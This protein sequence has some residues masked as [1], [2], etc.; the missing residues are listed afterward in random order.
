MVHQ[1]VTGS[2]VE[3][4]GSHPSVLS[5][6]TE[7]HSRSHCFSHKATGEFIPHSKTNFAERHKGEVALL[8]EVSKSI[9]QLLSKK[10]KAFK[11]EFSCY[12]ACKVTFN[13][14]SNLK[15]CVS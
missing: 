3:Q 15:L 6:Y 7:H 11:G 5:G 10:K 2:L 13:K 1:A 12:L 9:F 4:V 8:G 14:F